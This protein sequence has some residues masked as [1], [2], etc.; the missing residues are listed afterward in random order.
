MLKSL[1]SVSTVTKEKETQNLSGKS[2]FKRFAVLFAVICMLAVFAI[3]CSNE[4]DTAEVDI[5]FGAMSETIAMSLYINMMMEPDQFEGQTVR[6][7]GMYE[8]VAF[9]GRMFHMLVLADGDVCCPE[10]LFEFK[11]DEETL[12]EEGILS[13]G[14]N[15]EVFGALS[16]Y[17]MNGNEFIYVAADSIRIVS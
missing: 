2:I 7:A 8:G 6:L 17:E 12:M 3:G 4:S 13:T 9:D 5:D 1:M 15:I 11:M 16:L 14:A 10:I